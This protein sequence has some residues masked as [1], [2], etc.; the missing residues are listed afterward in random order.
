M[1]SLILAIPVVSVLIACGDPDPQV[2]RV[3]IDT[4][5]L[6]AV[7]ASCYNNNTV[8]VDIG[9]GNTLIEQLW[10]IWAGKDNQSNYLDLPFQDW[11]L[12]DVRVSLSA[13]GGPVLIVGGP[14]VWTVKRTIPN[15]GASNTSEETLSVS[16][17]QEPGSTGT[18]TMLVKEA[19]TNTTDFRSCE[20]SFPFFA[21]RIPVDETTAVGG[22]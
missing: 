10:T 15:T 21:R 19:N 9:T 8:P 7:P 16:F 4:S 1:R 13:G 12:G 17:D 2:Y 18:G 6:K 3:A 11:R 14:K 22:Q 5:A 20:A